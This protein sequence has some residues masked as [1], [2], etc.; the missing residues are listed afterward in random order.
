MLYVNKNRKYTQLI[1]CLLP[2]SLSLA[3]LIKPAWIFLILCIIS[4][5]AV[6]GLIPV[7]R[8]RESLFMFI[9]VAFAGLP[10]NI[11]LAYKFLSLEIYFL[12]FFLGDAL[13]AVLMCS[14]LFCAEELIFGVMARM[15]WKK[16]YKINLL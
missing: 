7:F 9:L 16:Q 15:I 11:W 3:F 14:V 13:I 12:G 1:F 8:K 5:F 10:I 2:I 6:V 4:L